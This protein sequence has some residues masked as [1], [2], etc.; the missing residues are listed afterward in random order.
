MEVLAHPVFAG[1]AAAVAAALWF[2]LFGLM[3]MATRGATPQPGPP[4]GQFGPESPALAGLMTNGWRFTGHAVAATLLDLAARRLVSI[5][6][7]GPELALVRLGRGEAPALRPYEQM[8]LD[9]VRALAVDGVVATGALA[10]GNRNL[11]RW[12]KRFR[13]AVIDESRRLGFSQRRWGR[14]NRRLLLASAAVPAAA[15]A[16]LGLNVPEDGAGAAYGIGMLVFVGLASLVERLNTER[17]T[18]AGALVAGRWLGVREHLAGG[19]FAEQPAA[20]VTV[21][22]Q[23]LAYAAAMGLAPRAVA[24]LP[25]AVAAD[26]SRAWSDYG[27]RWHLVEVRYGAPGPWGLIWGRTSWAVVGNGLLAGSGA[28][29]LAIVGVILVSVLLGWEVSNPIA[30]AL[31]AGVI[32][33]AVPIAL[34][35]ADR[36]AQLTVQGQLVR[37]RRHQVGGSGDS[38][39]TYTY[40]IAIDDGRSRA[41]RAFALEEK[42]FDRLA[43][44]D[45]VRAR[46]GR[47]LGRVREIEV[48]V[49]SRHR[50]TPPDPHPAPAR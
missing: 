15:T 13:K 4:T 11:D 17:G 38:P 35:L 2:L 21:W 44:G 32:V 23:T 18:A 29:T 40:W 25:I 31:T 50:G 39:V 49:P 42:D 5:E 34:V 16:L 3:A 20:A 14:A 43:E 30:L 9:H 45:L 47:W 12:R 33:A 26:E 36:A 8:V 28:F 48:L 37:C 19:R 46:M 6:E 10:E 7:I 22:G 41:G 24:G 1:S 27:G